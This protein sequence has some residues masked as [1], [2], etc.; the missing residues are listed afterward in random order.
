MTAQDNNQNTR[1]KNFF[2]IFKMAGKST[3]R[4]C[5]NMR[6]VPKDQSE[7]ESAEGSCCDIKIVPKGQE[8]EDKGNNKGC[9]C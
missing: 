6:I 2:D 8:T 1:K 7:K 9:C 5:C 3:D 4:G